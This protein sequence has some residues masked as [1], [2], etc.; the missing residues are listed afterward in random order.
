MGSQRPKTLVRAAVAADAPACAAIYAPY[1]TDTAIT[2][3]SQP[4][5]AAEMQQRIEAAARGH[6]WFVLEEGG[7]VV[8]C[9]GAGVGGGAPEPV[10]RCMRPYSGGSPNAAFAWRQRE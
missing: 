7:R 3:E 10:A 6:A 9:A 5:P 2:F 8:G 1:V 4:P